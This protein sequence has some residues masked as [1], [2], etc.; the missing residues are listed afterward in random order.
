MAIPWEFNI[1]QTNWKTNERAQR[2]TTFAGKHR[3]LRLE[4]KLLGYSDPETL[5]AKK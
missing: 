5:W 3:I 1:L 2:D 4:R